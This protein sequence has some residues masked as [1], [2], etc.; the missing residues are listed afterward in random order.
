MFKGTQQHLW[1]TQFRRQVGDVTQKLCTLA[2]N[3][4]REKKKN[5]YLSLLS[6]SRRCQ[7]E[8]RCSVWEQRIATGLD[9]EQGS[10]A[11]LDNTVWKVLREEWTI[12]SSTWGSASLTSEF[13]YIQC[14]GQ[15][16]LPLPLRR[17]Q[18][19]NRYQVKPKRTV[20]WKVFHKNL[21]VPLAL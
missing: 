2:Q 15:G 10:S 19:A 21:S 20:S 6:P 3:T 7:R 9:T 14:T 5:D 8:M 18:D 16:H 17:N 4:R 13:F 11:G 12:N 1:S